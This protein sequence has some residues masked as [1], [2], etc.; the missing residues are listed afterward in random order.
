[1]SIPNP[2][3]TPDPYGFVEIGGS[4]MPGVL[5][6][7]TYPD[8]TYEYAE[9]NGYGATQ[10]TVYRTTKVITGIEVLHF[11][12]D[13]PNG[14]SGDFEKLRDVFMP[15]LIPGW[16]NKITGKPRAFPL[17][18]PDAQWLGVRRVH[19]THFACP[20]MQTP[21]D[22]SRWYKMIFQEDMPQ[23]RIPTGPP[24]PANIN[25]PPAPT[26]VNEAA[27]L[28]LLADFKGT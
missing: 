6:S 3:T 25:G 10:V 11:L 16:P 21:G 12:R 14:A 7:I 27:L 1:M 20:K 24:E 28:K 9:Q 4:R 5:T 22:P 13:T 23:T 2:Y 15:L 26:T 19:L 8:R 18:H 17:T